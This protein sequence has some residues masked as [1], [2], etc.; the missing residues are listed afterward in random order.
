MFSASE[1][2]LKIRLCQLTSFEVIHACLNSINSTDNEFM[3]RWELYSWWKINIYSKLATKFHK[4][5]KSR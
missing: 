5:G 1:I 3:A 2:L 4:K